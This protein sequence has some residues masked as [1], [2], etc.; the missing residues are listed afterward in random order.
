MELQA[1][2]DPSWPSRS[3]TRS[4]HYAAITAQYENIRRIR[5]DIA[6]H[7]YT[8]DSAAEARGSMR[9]PRTTLRWRRPRSAATGPTW[10]AAKIRRW[11]TF[12]CARAGG[13][14]KRPGL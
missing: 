14:L 10:A 7:L 1:E 9:R 12:P 4:E 8:M 5:H 2:N 3:T 11:T 13:D 6:N